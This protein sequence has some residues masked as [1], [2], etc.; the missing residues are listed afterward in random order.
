MSESLDFL[1]TKVESKKLNQAVPRQSQEK[2]SDGLRPMSLREGLTLASQIEVRTTSAI[3]PN[4]S[5][6]VVAKNMFQDE[7]A[8]GLRW[9]E[10]A[11]AV[12][13]AYPGRGGQRTVWLE[14]SFSLAFKLDL[15]RRYGLGGVAIEDV[16]LNPQAASYWEP[17]RTYAE[18]GSVALAQPNGT[19]LKPVW[20]AQA[21][22]TE[23]NAK[24][25]VV[26]KAPA[27]P[28]A[29]DLS[30]VISDGVTRAAQKIVLD[31]RP[32]GATPVPSPTPR[33]GAAP[34]A[35]P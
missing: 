18:A 20:L 34:T 13:F 9:D 33:P 32:P 16:S 21:G 12:S 7:G 2:G 10:G 27:Q 8:T 11:Y 19:L 35:R 1:K 6:V 5:V 4:S 17:L 22:S 28:G 31:V 25:N 29:Y 24:G 26:W 14:N 3:T 30:L 15:A 23:P